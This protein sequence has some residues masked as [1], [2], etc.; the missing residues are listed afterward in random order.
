M[1]YGK[2]NVYCFYRYL[3]FSNGLVESGSLHNPLKT[4]ESREEWNSQ[5]SYLEKSIFSK[6]KKIASIFE[7]LLCISNSSLYGV[8]LSVTP[9]MQP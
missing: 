7:L 8:T 5:R 4:W 2:D 1:Q 3:F 9:Y 6:Q